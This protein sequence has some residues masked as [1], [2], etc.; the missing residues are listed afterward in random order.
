MKC[1]TP[2]R[3]TENKK[4][5]SMRGAALSYLKVLLD[6]K[7]KG[8]TL[9]HP[10]KPK[11]AKLQLWQGRILT[12]YHSCHCV[13]SLCADSN[14]IGDWGPAF[15]SYSKVE[16]KELPFDTPGLR[17]AAAHLYIL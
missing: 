7:M 4:L 1:N 12:L 13:T 15:H 2:S 14:G 11:T 3:F 5:D 10:P 9:T 17:V 6:E 8:Q 16:G